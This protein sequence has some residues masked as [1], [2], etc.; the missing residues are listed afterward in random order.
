MA[1]LSKTAGTS[2]ITLK[3]VATTTVEKSAAQ[4]VSAKFG[5]T[6][7]VHVGR[8]ATTALTEGVRVRIEGS[9]KASGDGHWYPLAEFQTDTA[10]AN[11]WS[12]AGAEAAGQTVLEANPTAGAIG[13]IIFLDN[14]TIANG[15]FHRVFKITTNVSEEI[16]DGLVNAQ[17]SA[18]NVYNKAEMFAAQ[19]DLT[20][21]SRLRVVVDCRNTGQNI[22]VE[23]HMVT[24]D[25]IA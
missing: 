6:V 20:A 16:E 8:R 15:E 25:S 18:T 3:S 7:F 23:A 17:A 14:A 2:L 11:T 12:L 24:G 21:V 10:A 19:L 4:D 5:A 9:S 13:D 22:A 1:A